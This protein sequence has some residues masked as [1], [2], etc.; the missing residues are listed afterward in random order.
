MRQGELFGRQ[1][2]DIDFDGHRIHVRRSLW[3]GELGTP[4]SRRSRRAIDMAPTLEAALHRLSSA[5]RLSEF[6]FCSR[7]GTPMDTDNFRH[8]E[9]PKA[10]RRAGLRHIRFHD[11]RHTYTSL[12]IRPGRASEVHPGAAR[13]RVDPDNARPLRAPHARD[14]PG[15]SAEAR[16]TRVRRGWSA[17]AAETLGAHRHRQAGEREQNRSRTHDG[18]AIAVA[19]RRFRWLRGLDLNQRPLNY[20][21]FSKQRQS[22]RARLDGS[23]AH[24]I[25]G[26]RHDRRGRGCGGGAWPLAHSAHG[27]AVVERH[28]HGDECAPREEEHQHDDDAH[29]PHRPAIVPRSHD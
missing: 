4:K 12:L 19:T 15:G 29:G 5:E 28:R 11:L 13:A 23:G 25:S 9:F 24:E 17:G 6:V 18:L 1:W 10:L 21:P 20:E 26:C 7:D 8:R 22:Q 14:P 3:H 2:G 16:S 27:R